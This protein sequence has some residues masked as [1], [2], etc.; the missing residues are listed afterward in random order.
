MEKHELSEELYYSVK[1]TIQYHAQNAMMAVQTSE[2]GMPIEKWRLSNSGQSSFRHSAPES[3]CP[4]GSRTVSGRTT[5]IVYNDPKFSFGKTS[6]WHLMTCGLSPST[7]NGFQVRSNDDI[8]IRNC[9]TLICF[10]I[11]GKFV[12]SHR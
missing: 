11:Y 5:G 7:N 1:I 9:V 4:S 8:R 2:D 3:R 6:D 12:T 10:T